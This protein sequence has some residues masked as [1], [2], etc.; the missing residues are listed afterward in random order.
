MSCLTAASARQSSPHAPFARLDSLLKKQ[1]GGWAGWK[2]PLA[3]LFNAERKRLRGRFETELLT[4]IGSDIEKHH[5]TSAFLVEPEYLQGNSP[6]PELSLFIKHRALSLLR[7][8]ED[9][10]SQGEIV[11]LSVTAAILS[12]TMGLGTLATAYKNEA[13]R[14]L[15]AKPLL[16]SS[17]PVLDEGRRKLY[18]SISS[19]VTRKGASV[20]IS[21]PDDAPQ[22]MVNAG[23]VDS[24][25]ISK[26]TPE[27]P[28]EARAAGAAGE[29]KVKIV[30]DEAGRVIWAKAVSGHQLLHRAAEEAARQTKFEPV[31]LS[32][33][34]VRAAG[35]LIYK[36]GP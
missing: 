23:V 33:K 1:P 3:T 10:S 13:E 8:R 25:A 18:D 12:E 24:V 21:E 32:G 4:Y 15:A 14:L 6:L 30:F 36:F 2:Q 17:F 22:A 9:D 35:T 20:F 11:K 29:V 5:W 19:D 26:P 27:Y 34:P 16:Q 28:T 7:D 31:K